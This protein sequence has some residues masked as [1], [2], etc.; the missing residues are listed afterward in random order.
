MSVILMSLVLPLLS[1]CIS[2][3]A[4]LQERTE[5]LPARDIINIDNSVLRHEVNGRR[6][7]WR[8]PVQLVCISGKIKG[9]FNYNFAVHN[10]NTY[11][12]NE[13]QLEYI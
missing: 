1:L 11:A 3:S 13:D 10:I 6:K 7:S 9:R 12:L 4:G 5:L 8:K 2:L